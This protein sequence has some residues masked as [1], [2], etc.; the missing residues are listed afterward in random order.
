MSFRTYHL[1]YYLFRHLLILLI[2]L[3]IDRMKFIRLIKL[4]YVLQSQL[5]VGQYG[6]A[7]EI[8]L[9]LISKRVQIFL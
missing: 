6:H 9:C 7:D 4:E 8:I 3:V 2:C 5:Y 1:A